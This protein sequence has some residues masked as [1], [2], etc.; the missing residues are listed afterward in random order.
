[1]IL[2]NQIP[3][4]S[5]ELELS[6]IDMEDYKFVVGETVEIYYK[7]TDTYQQA[8]VEQVLDEMIQIKYINFNQADNNNYQNNITWFA[9]DTDKLQPKDTYKNQYKVKLYEYFE[10]LHEQQLR[11]QNPQGTNQTRQGDG[12]QDMMGADYRRN[13]N[14]FDDNSDEEDEISDDDNFN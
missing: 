7:K 8:T 14:G 9:C 6:L 3:A 10:N 12:D 4:E 13:N 1:M 5:S 11:A 2:R